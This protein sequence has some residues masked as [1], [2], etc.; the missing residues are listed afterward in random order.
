MAIQLFFLW[1]FIGMFLC[2]VELKMDLN[3]I[4]V[5]YT[6]RWYV[7]TVQMNEMER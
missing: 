6:W 1:E 7:H 2:Q 3:V 5:L 4:L